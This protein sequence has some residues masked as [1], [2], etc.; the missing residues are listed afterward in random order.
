MS[1]EVL[2]GQAKCLGLVLLTVHRRDESATLGRE[3]WLRRFGVSEPAPSVGV[4]P[5]LAPRANNW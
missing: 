2:A 4:A 3:D 1:T 5:G